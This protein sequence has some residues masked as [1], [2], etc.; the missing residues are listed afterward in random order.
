MGESLRMDCEGKQVHLQMRENEKVSMLITGKSRMGKTFFASCLGRKLI[1]EGE[2]VH[3][4]DLGDK[5]SCA[6]KE[7]LISEGAELHLVE[8]NGIT[9]CFKEKEEISACGRIITNA[10]GFRSG[11]AVMVIKKAIKS[12]LS[13]RGQE[14]SIGDLRERLET[15]V[16]EAPEDAEW[17]LKIWERLDFCDG[18]ARIKIKVDMNKEFGADSVIWDFSG[19]DDDFV[20]VAAYLISFCL[21]SR[22]K[23]RFRLGMAEKR[24]FLII[25]EFQ[26]LDCDRK[27]VVGTCLTEGQKYGLSLILI[28][29]FLNGNFSEAVISQFKQGGF[30]FYFRLTEEEAAMLSKGLAMNSRERGI[31]YKKLMQLPQGQCL[32]IGRNY[33]KDK[34]N[35][36]ET[37]RFVEIKEG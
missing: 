30:R 32:M 33:I 2:S 5:W 11:N 15:D 23:R 31:L 21:L 12:L 20:Q 18:L 27:S 24:T 7:R 36:T 4:I 1:S 6:D 16:E 37:Y 29:Q 28:T 10:L 35:S 19:M 8:R 13:K 14:F 34:N 17:R 26:N 22:Q 9:L 3:L 25:D